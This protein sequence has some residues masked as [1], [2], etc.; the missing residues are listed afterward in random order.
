M[1][2]GVIWLLLAKQE[3]YS[4]FYKWQNMAGYGWKDGW[5]SVT[6]PKAVLSHFK[7]LVI[8]LLCVY[9]VDLVAFS[10]CICSYWAILSLIRQS[11]GRTNLEIP[12]KGQGHPHLDNFHLHY[13]SSGVL[14]FLPWG[15][16]IALLWCC[17]SW[18]RNGWAC[19]KFSKKQ[20]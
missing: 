20:M 4:H 5:I 10:Q 9:L 18:H 14:H 19:E 2:R 17:T 3:I 16:V 12:K 6:I 13:D 7:A 1:W 15:F 8:V 11:R